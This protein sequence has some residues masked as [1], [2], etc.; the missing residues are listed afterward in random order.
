MLHEIAHALTPNDKG[1]G[2]EWKRMALK[3]GATP[4]RCADYKPIPGPW[5]VTCIECGRSWREVRREYIHCRLH[6]DIPLQWVNTETGETWDG[7]P[8]LPK[9]IYICSRCGS[10]GLNPNKYPLTCECRYKQKEWVK[11]LLAEW[12][13]KKREAQRAGAKTHPKAPH[14]Q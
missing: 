7:K 1:H 11:T 4:K 5:K 3:I 14:A 6:P 13:D 9:Y 12:L 8:S 2:T 10:F